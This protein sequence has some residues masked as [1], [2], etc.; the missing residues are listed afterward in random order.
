M[1]PQ[2]TTIYPTGLRCLTSKSLFVRG[3]RT[4]KQSVQ[5]LGML[6]GTNKTT[7]STLLQQPTPNCWSC[8]WKLKV[9][10]QLYL[11]K[12]NTPP[13]PPP[14]DLTH[15]HHE[16]VLSH[17][18]PRGVYVWGADL[19]LSA[20]MQV[21]RWGCLHLKSD[22]GGESR[23]KEWRERPRYRGSREGETLG[24]A[25]SLLHY[26]TDSNTAL[27]QPP[28]PTDP[29]TYHNTTNW[30]EDWQLIRVGSWPWCWR[31]L[32]SCSIH[33]VNRAGSVQYIF[34]SRKR[35]N[36]Q[37]QNIKGQNTNQG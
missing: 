29:D 33:A 37:S 5:C 20:S 11:G 7:L 2:R 32:L 36:L 1:K 22:R 19:K 16:N 34:M 6:P 18:P 24:A 14:L 9:G 4:Y 27:S 26:D 30:K 12:R 15:T 25:S 31:M 10:T 23:Q 17:N 35:L 8:L 3:E 13:P 21:W 28:L